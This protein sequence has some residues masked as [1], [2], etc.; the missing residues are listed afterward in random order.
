MKKM[1][2]IIL[3]GCNGKMGQVI[4][5]CLEDFENCEIVAGFDINSAVLNNY[6]VYD[7]YDSFKDEADLIIDFSHP[8]VLEKLLDYAVNRNLP[9]VVATT[10]LDEKQVE[11]IHSASNQIPVFFSANMS[12][13][14][15][16]ITELAKKAAQALEG[17][18]IEIIERHHNQKI[19]APSG[20]ALHLAGEISSSLP[21][22]YR[23]EYDRH[24][25][26]KKRDKNEIGMHSV[27]GGTI[28][29][30]H[31]VLFAGRDEVISIRHQALSKDIFAVGSIRAGL[32]IIGKDPGL[33]SMKDL[34]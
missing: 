14:I 26:R 23:Y 5:S 21:E 24:S 10:G 13:G 29:G 20:T 32:F 27:R 17:F 3:S 4:T 6:P 28:V 19:D 8:S 30:D 25:K 22:P 2:K 16:L 31:E 33:Y 9:I 1:K 34:I 18:D 15:N 11:R 7:N 12:I